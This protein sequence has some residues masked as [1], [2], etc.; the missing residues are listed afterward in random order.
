MTTVKD[1]FA[2][3]QKLIEENAALKARLSP[4]AKTTTATTAAT[5]PPAVVIP[6]L[7]PAEKA[8][9][10]ELPEALAALKTEKDPVRLYELSQRIWKLARNQ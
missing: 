7:T 3:K 4:L 5:T 6:Y 9:I 1:Y 2:T 10:E 8:Q